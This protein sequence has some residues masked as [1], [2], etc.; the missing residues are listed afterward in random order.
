MHACIRVGERILQREVGNGGNLEKTE[1][2]TRQAVP[3]DNFCV[4]L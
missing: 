2:N 3:T 1:G 4:V